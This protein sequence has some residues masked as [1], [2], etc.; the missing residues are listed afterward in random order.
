[1]RALL[2]ALVVLPACSSRTAKTDEQAFIERELARLKDALAKR[3]VSG[4]TTG[5]A[6]TVAAD[7]VDKAL[8]AEIEHLCSVEAPKLYLEEALV[9]ARKYKAA[10]PPKEL[11][12]LACM[13]LFVDEAFAA[14][15]KH[16]SDD[17]GLKALADEYT[18][19]C[20]DRV[21]KLRAP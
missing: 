18:A 12:E 21:A 7:S 8:A 10:P 11:P 4:V 14:I 19:L 15:A 17:P 3:S 6:L 5:C 1:M 13:Q 20:P 16:P 2:L 9:D